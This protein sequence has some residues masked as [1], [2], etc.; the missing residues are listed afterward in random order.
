MTVVISAQAQT[1][2]K[3]SQSVTSLELWFDYDWR[4][5]DTVF[6]VDTSATHATNHVVDNSLCRMKY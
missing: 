3:G 5:I 1:A 4:S 2:Q 6:A